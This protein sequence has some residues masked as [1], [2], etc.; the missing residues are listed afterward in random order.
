MLDHA[1]QIVPLQE[2][3]RAEIP[4][5]A[6]CSAPGATPE[7]ALAAVRLARVD[8]IREARAEGRPVPPPDQPE[9]AGMET[10]SPEVR[11]GLEPERLQDL[12]QK[13]RI[14]R[15]WLFGSVLR[16]DFGP[17]SDVDVLVEFDPAAT[18][19]LFDLV[20]LTDE[21]QQWFD[22]PVDLVELEALTNPLRREH[23]LAT[24][25]LLH[26]STSRP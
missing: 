11:L 17:A 25:R 7:E 18:W 12:C 8:W 1:V 19:S 9:R 20:D 4:A 5:L 23:I 16:D 14:R 24:R 6:G 2:G 21:L 22:R 15:F 13:W 26:D 10:R 3:Y